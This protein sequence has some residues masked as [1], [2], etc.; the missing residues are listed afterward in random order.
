M[1]FVM[2]V[3]FGSGQAGSG[4]PKV[5]LMLPV[6]H[7]MQCISTSHSLR[8]ASSVASGAAIV[9]NP[10]LITGSTWSKF[11]ASVWATQHPIAK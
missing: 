11:K 4:C 5:E 2:C 7:F 10:S 8:G 1:L 6:I 3:C 9:F